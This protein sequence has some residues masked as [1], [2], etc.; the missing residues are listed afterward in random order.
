MFAPS[1]P[2]FISPLN[3]PLYAATELVFASKRFALEF[4]ISFVLSYVRL[5]NTSPPPLD[6]TSFIAA[7]IEDLSVV[8]RSDNAPISALFA[9]SDSLCVTGPFFSTR[10]SVISFV[11]DSPPFTYKSPII[12]F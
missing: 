5:S 1:C 12:D 4:I 7:T 9:F 11:D 3:V 2:I 6:F 8:A 10:H